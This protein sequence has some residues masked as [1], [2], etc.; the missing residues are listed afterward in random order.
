VAAPAPCAHNSKALD[1]L[2]TQGPWPSIP[3]LQPKA[4]LT[5][6]D[7]AGQPLNPTLKH[8]HTRACQGHRL[9]THTLNKQLYST[10]QLY[11]WQHLSD[12]AANP[13]PGLPGNC[14][15]KQFGYTKLAAVAS[16]PTT[17][18]TPAAGTCPAH[19]Y[20]PCCLANG[21]LPVPATGQAIGQLLQCSNAQL[22]AFSVCLDLNGALD[23]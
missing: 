14:A 5:T 1:Q 22:L 23:R 19:M 17:S 11:G 21:S 13:D 16:A 18:C 2:E 15:A 3:A 20:I 10:T 7:A 9:R 4:S 8:K 12:A 6:A